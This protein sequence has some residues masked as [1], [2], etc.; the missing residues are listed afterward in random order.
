MSQNRI[1]IEA[2]KENKTYWKDIWTFRSLFYFLAW[3]DILVRYKQTTIGLAWALIRPFLMIAVF[4]S[5]NMI[6][7]GQDKNPHG[8]PVF[9]LI[10]AAILPWNFFSTAFSECSSS[11]VANS[12]LV[13][14]VYFPR[15]IVPASTV[16]VC[17]IDFFISF[18]IIIG[19]MIYYQFFP[20]W[21]ILW[22][23]VF[24]LMALVTALGTGIYFSALNVKFR[25]FRYIIPFM[26]QFGLYISPI[27]FTSQFIYDHK[28][29]PQF[30]KYIYSM[31]PMV[32][33]IDGFRWCLNGDAI[34]FHWVEFSISVCISLFFLVIGIITFRKMEKGFAD[35]I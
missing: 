13:S 4:G 10:A 19:L 33:V 29:I 26:V 30:V 18:V 16:I 5:V 3:R 15:L 34:Q 8:V 27:M 20:G 32:S 24:L 6:L 9:I 25:D 7:M 14:K 11:L 35:V 31:N 21:Q 2:G 23:P 17:L 28:S 1:V 22:L 12:N